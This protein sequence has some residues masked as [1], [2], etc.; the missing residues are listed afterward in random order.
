M[1]ASSCRSCGASIVW[2]KTK[3]GKSIP[4]DFTSVAQTDTEYDST[5]HVA[6]FA[7]CPEGKRWSKKGKT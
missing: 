5:R 7:T 3:A 4:V 1:N 6:H 2:F